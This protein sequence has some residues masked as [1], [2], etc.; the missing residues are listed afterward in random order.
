MTSYDWWVRWDLRRCVETS[1]FTEWPS[2]FLPCSPKTCGIK[3]SG[4]RFGTVYKCPRVMTIK[5]DSLSR[6]PAPMDNAVSPE[7]APGRGSIRN[8]FTSS[9]WLMKS[10]RVKP[11]YLHFGRVAVGIGSPCVA[12]RSSQV[13][14]WVTQDSVW[15]EMTS[16]VGSASH[17]WRE[18]PDGRKRATQVKKNCHPDFRQKKKKLG[19]FTNSTKTGKWHRQTFPV[20]S[21]IFLCL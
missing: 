12:L 2:V 13:G 21:V 8:W 16:A 1:L 18:T 3:G 19:T 17:S 6:L 9:L 7:T 11:T 14:N 15:W 20:L 10:A 4:S 5:S